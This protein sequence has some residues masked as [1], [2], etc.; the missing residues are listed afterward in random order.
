MSLLNSITLYKKLPFSKNYNYV[1]NEVNFQRISYEA[2]GSDYVEGT[3]PDGDIITRFDC[4][5]INDYK[6]RKRIT[7]TRNY[8]SSILNKYNASIFRVEPTRN[9][10]DDR[11]FF[12]ADG[13]G[14]N[15]NKVMR[16]ALLK[17]QIDGKCYLYLNQPEV[18]QEILS[19]AQEKS[20]DI[21]PYIKIIPI[22]NVI[23]SLSISEK[24]EEILIFLTNEEGEEIARW[25]DDEYYIDI[26]YNPKNYNIEEISEKYIH[27]FDL[28]PVTEIKPFSD[29]QSKPISY[30]QKT[31]VNILSLLQQEI[32]DHTFTKHILSGV[33][34]KDEKEKIIYGSKRMI[35]LEDSSADLKTI[36]SDVTQAQS[37]RDQIKLEEDNLYMAAGFGNQNALE[38]SNLSGY[39]LTILKD[40]FFINCGALKDALE[41]AENYILSLI[42]KDNFA[43]SVYAT[44]YIADDSGSELEKLRNLLSLNLPKTF[45]N[46]AIKDYINKYFNIRE[47]DKQKIEMELENLT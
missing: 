47:E 14:N 32:V 12:D 9:I 27:G 30:S 2:S 24:L 40:D 6:N 37:L 31:I 19:L 41:S 4:E 28:I 11:I 38:P 35:V 25:M 45:K 46:L 5:E 44:R 3:S 8:V 29:A 18:E 10:P 34:I 20:S 7:P 33:R 17:S 21:R 26:K 1:L 39:A 13:Y 15:L 42:F 22:E 16:E 23:N 36:G 43:Q